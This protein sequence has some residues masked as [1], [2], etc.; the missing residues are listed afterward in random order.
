MLSG[1][2]TMSQDVK[3]QT[4]TADLL[5]IA[6]K[7]SKDVQF[8][9]KNIL[10][11]LNYKTGNLKIEMKNSDFYSKGSQQKSGIGE[12]QDVIN[13][14]LVGMLPIEQILNQKESNKEYTV[15]LQLINDN[16]DFSKVLNFKMN[17]MR[18]SQQ[19][20]SYRVFTFTGQLYN[21]DIQLPAFDGFDNEVEI[22]IMFNA[23]WN[24]Q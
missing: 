12:E 1:L 8:E 7:D 5:I 6:T 13:Y 20:G 9:N 11:N 2:V 16:I 24:G 14:T 15:E 19:S 10:A 18:T 23:F 17:V 3:F 4:Y 22:R 21:N